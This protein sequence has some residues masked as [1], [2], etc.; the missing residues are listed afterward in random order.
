MVR[1]P[2]LFGLVL[3]SAGLLAIVPETV[4]A[5]SFVVLQTESFCAMP[6][7]GDLATWATPKMTKLLM[8]AGGA[9]VL[10]GLFGAP[11]EGRGRL[12]LKTALAFGLV[13]FF[14]GFQWAPTWEYI[15]SIFGD[16]SIDA[17][18]CGM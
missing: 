17:M 6:F 3:A 1:N 15:G 16:G 13:M 12:S 9:T 5:A 7:F 14:V 2:P 8:F 10:Y 18:T 4:A 11:A